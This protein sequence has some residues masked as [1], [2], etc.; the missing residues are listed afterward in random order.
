MSCRTHYKPRRELSAAQ[1]DCYVAMATSKRRKQDSK[2]VSS[3]KHEIEYTG[4]RVAK[5]TRT[6]KKK[7]KRAVK[8][9]KTSLGRST[10]RKKVVSRAKKIA[11]RAKKTTKR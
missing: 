1:Q 5:A 7:A 6:P 2:R 3:Q 8:A 10:G 9:A 4:G 11:S